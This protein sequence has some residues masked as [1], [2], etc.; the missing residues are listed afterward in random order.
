MDPLAQA[1]AYYDFD[2]TTARIVYSGGA[3]HPKYFN[4]DDT[5]PDGYVT[6]ND[7]WTNYWREGQNA[8]L[9]WGSGTGTG[10]G[11]KSLGQELA[12]SQAFA[13]CQAEKVFRTVC[14]RSPVDAADRAQ[15]ATMAQ[16]FRNNNFN[17]RRVFAESAV[18][19]MGD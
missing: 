3:V 11:A 5:F 2:E 18:Y 16:T 14:L 8:L 1:F 17:L 12:A 19:C 15:V 7:T 10:A 13:T 4:N 9:G 6:P